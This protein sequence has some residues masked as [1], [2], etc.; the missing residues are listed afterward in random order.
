MKDIRVRSLQDVGIKSL[1]EVLNTL[2]VQDPPTQDIIN[3][4]PLIL[5]KSNFS[6]QNKYY[7]QIKGMA[8]GTEMSPSYDNIFMDEFERKILAN[9]EKHLQFGGGTSMIYSPSG[10]MKKNILEHS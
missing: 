8:M 1:Q 2:R 10:H 6:F 4:I 5:T 3:L 9:A 7:L